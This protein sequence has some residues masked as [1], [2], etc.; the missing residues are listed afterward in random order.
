M[1]KWKPFKSHAGKPLSWKIECDDLSD[2]DIDCLA[3]LVYTK[4]SYEEVSYPSTNSAN[5]INL[6]SKLER[7]KSFNADYDYLIVD[8]VLT[9]GKSM[10]DIYEH[11]H[12]NHGYKIKGVVIFARNECPDWI[13]PIFQLNKSFNI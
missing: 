11:L 9:T 2:E 12:T 3:K 7:H 6:V 5:V 4:Y 8:D 13:T 1:F 10:N